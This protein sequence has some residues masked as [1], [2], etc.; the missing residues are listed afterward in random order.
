MAD[1]AAG[2]RERPILFSGAMVR[3]ILDGAKTQTRRVVT[4]RVNDEGQWVVTRPGGWADGRP[5]TSEEIVGQGWRCP[6]G[7][8]GD[9]LWVRE[10]WWPRCGDA[11]LYGIREVV[12]RCDYGGTGGCLTPRSWRP[13]IHMPRWASRLTLELT[14]VRVQRVQEISKEDA[15]AEG[16]ERTPCLPID[17]RDW[18]R[19]R[20]DALNAKRGYPWDANPWVWAL[21]FRRVGPCP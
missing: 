4:R 9:R 15:T 7:Q 10:T 3:A 12:Y 19:G 18:F 13:S 14:A 17:P 20:W 2:T 1:L 8:P 5:H 11:H 16:F 21:T 6:Y